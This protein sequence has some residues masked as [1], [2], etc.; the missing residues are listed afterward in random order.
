MTQ[1]VEG[2]RTE[3]IGILDGFDAGA[4]VPTLGNLQNLGTLLRQHQRIFAPEPAAA[5]RHDRDPHGT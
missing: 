2:T 4:G 3:L 1:H 5:A